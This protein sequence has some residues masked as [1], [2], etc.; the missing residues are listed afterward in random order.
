MDRFSLFDLPEDEFLKL[1]LANEHRHQIDDRIAP[2]PTLEGPIAPNSCNVC[3]IQFPSSDDQRTHFKLDWHLC[4]LKRLRLDPH[5]ASLSETEFND[6][7]DDMASLSGSDVSDDSASAASGGEEEQEDNS[8]T[9]TAVKAVKVVVGSPLV[10]FRDERGE[11]FRTWRAVLTQKGDATTADLR[12]LHTK[13][14]WIVLL[15][16]GGHFAGVVF[17]GKKQLAHKTFHRY[18]VRKQAG[19]RQTTHDAGGHHPKSAGASIRRQMEVALADDIQHLLTLW[20]AY[21][22]SAQL[23]FMHAPGVNAFVFFKGDHAPLKKTDE[24]IRNIPFTTRRPTMTEAVR[25]HTVLSTFER[26]IEPQQQQQQQDNAA[27]ANDG[28]DIVEDD[29]TIA[30]RL[31]EAEMIRIKQAEK[32]A[33]R[34]QA[35]QEAAPRELTPTEQLFAACKSCNLDQVRSLLSTTTTTATADNLIQ[36]RDEVGRTPL[37]YGAIAVTTGGGSAE[38]VDMITPL[39]M[40][41]ADVNAQDDKGWTPLH[42]AAAHGLVSN[43]QLLFDFNADPSLLTSDGRTPYTVT[44]TKAVQALFRQWRQQRPTAYD[45]HTA[46]VPDQ[47]QHDAAEQAA[48]ARAKA[49]RAAKK[50]KAKSKAAATAAGGGDHLVPLAAST[51]DAADGLQTSGKSS[52]TMAKLSVEEVQEMR[53][54]ASVNVVETVA[55]RRRRLATAAERRFQTLQ[56]P[57]Q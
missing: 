8:D 14:L 11:V 48:A 19:G 39:L 55:D 1:E 32:A 53:V 34:Q 17:D 2:E 42:F 28:V 44:S 16:R 5:A 52:S 20:S 33:A 56:P 12:S 40:A 7:C 27:M 29:E 9:R 36:Q 35:A 50:S 23:I 3:R 49:K 30:R 21:L 25:V 15:N 54:R 37:H 47:A 13:R 10:A 38:G 45:W 31:A 41:G 51:A 26:Y 46:Q 22:H 57:Q 4:N 24:R 18:V 43:C 6:I